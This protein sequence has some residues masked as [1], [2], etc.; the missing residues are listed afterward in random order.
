MRHDF[1]GVWRAGGGVTPGTELG[2]DWDGNRS[3]PLWYYSN[4][5]PLLP[6]H[7]HCSHCIFLTVSR[8]LSMTVTLFLVHSKVSSVISQLLPSDFLEHT[9][10]N[11]LICPDFSCEYVS[12]LSL[13]TS[14]KRPQTDGHKAVPTCRDTKCSSPSPITAHL[15]YSL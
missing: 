4:V 9:F 7:T 6:D 13:A 3:C 8:S 10:I 11:V 12:C 5:S 1:P 2:G 14:V 15:T